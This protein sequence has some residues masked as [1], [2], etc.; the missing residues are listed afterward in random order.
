[1]IQ[2]NVTG[3]S[4]PA[5]FCGSLGL[6]NFSLVPVSEFSCTLNHSHWRFLLYPENLF[7][8]VWSLPSQEKLQIGFPFLLGA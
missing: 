7:V 5:L 8:C 4:L 3:E 6:E 2:G 1:M